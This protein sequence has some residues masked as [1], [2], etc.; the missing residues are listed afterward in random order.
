MQLSGRK[1]EYIVG[2]ARAIAHGASISGARR[3]RQRRGDRAPDDAP[4]GRPVVRG[5]VPRPRPRPRRRVSAGDLAVR[6]AFARYYNRGRPLSDAA[7][8]RRARRWGA[9]QNLAVHYLLAGLRLERPQEAAPEPAR[10][11][12]DP[13][14]AE[15][16]RAAGRSPRRPLRGGHDVGRQS[17]EHLSFERLRMDCACGACARL[18]RLTPA[19]TWPDEIKKTPEG[20]TS[21]GRTAH[22]R[23]PVRSAPRPLSVRELHGRP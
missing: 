22:E 8:R 19:M 11:P 5:V 10:H 13:R 23:I 12:A 18:V 6:K 3:L 7:I 16:E 9:Y 1:A 17:R 14:T 20:C 21:A 4:R 15:P 2:I